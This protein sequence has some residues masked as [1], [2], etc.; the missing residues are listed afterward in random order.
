M[1][2]SHDRVRASVDNDCAVR[3]HHV[4]RCASDFINDAHVAMLAAAHELE[5]GGVVG[6]EERSVPSLD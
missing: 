1:L 3:S 6:H 2:A 5:V 4:K